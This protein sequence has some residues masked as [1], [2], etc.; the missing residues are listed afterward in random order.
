MPYIDRS[1]NS[2]VGRWWWTVDR[3]T[4]VLVLGL[5]VLGAL[6]SITSTPVVTERLAAYETFDM[7]RR[8]IAYTVLAII[9]F[10][11][12]SIAPVQVLRRFGIILT[13]VAVVLLLAT[14][15]IGKDYNN[16]TRWLSIF[17]VSLQPSELVKPG[18]ALFSAW[19]LSARR[20]GAPVPGYIIATG[21]YAICAVA[22][23]LQPDFGQTVIL[24]AIFG[25]QLFL[26]GI[27]ILLVM[28]LVLLCL[29]GVVGAYLTLPHVRSR[30]D[31]F[32]NT[33]AG[34]R[35]QVDF[36]LDALLSGGIFGRGPG[37][38]HVKSYLPDGHTDFIFSVIG[39]EFGLLACMGLVGVFFAIFMISFLRILKQK[40][41]FV[42]IAG[43]GLLVQFVGQSLINM[44]SA[45]VLIPPKGMPLP[46]ISYGGS[47][48]LG[49]AIMLG[50]LL[51]LGRKQSPETAPLD[52]DANYEPNW[53]TAKNA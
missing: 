26:T 32:L 44:A 43:T 8:Q 45:L 10:L 33:Q 46:F 24:T 19:M 23:I 14:L 27:P 9:I 6:L 40:D 29:L 42:L 3:W 50:A 12:I 4:L 48:L 25:A 35:S 37:E 2:L 28:G 49:T 31:G 53:G 1:D 52:Y 39:E 30:I 47:S 16:S 41:L 11:S 7:V 20:L 21:L 13:G 51:A 18:F 5:A 38:G 36:S 17:G 34:D 15:V 22:L